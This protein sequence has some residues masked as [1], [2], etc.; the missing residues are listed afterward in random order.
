M[1]VRTLD[2]FLILV[3]A[4]APAAETY[5]RLGFHVRPIAEHVSIGSANCVI[6]LRDTYLELFFLGRAPAA[7]QDAYGPR[8]AA[9]PGLTHVALHSDNLETDIASLTAKGVPSDEILSAKRR[10]VRPDGQEDFTASTS[11]YHWRERHRYLSLFH[12]V[13]HRPETIFIPEYCDHA[14][15]AVDVVRC[16]FQSED[17]ALDLGYFTTLFDG[18]PSDVTLDGFRFVGPRGEVSE[19]ITPT[20]AR[21]RYGDAMPAP[22]L[23]GLGALPLALHYQAGSM[24]RCEQHLRGEGFDVSHHGSALVVSAA[25][26]CGVVTVFQPA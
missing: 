23:A 10:I 5:R 13:H 22:G 15:S 1:A 14:N 3:E 8:L 4:L 20:A 2:H 21:A 24:S 6:H 25:Q 26:A 11:V 18:P 19:V 12:S 9:G 7:L 16:V 17:P